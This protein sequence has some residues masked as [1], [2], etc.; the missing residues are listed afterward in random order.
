LFWVYN[1]I[2]KIAGTD[3]ENKGRSEVVKDW[4]IEQDRADLQ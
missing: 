1:Q 2:K 3:M 4:G